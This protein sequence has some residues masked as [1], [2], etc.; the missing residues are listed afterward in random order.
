[1]DGEPGFAV[2]RYAL[3]FVLKRN[4]GTVNYGD[5]PHTAYRPKWLYAPS[6]H[7]RVYGV[8]TH[9]NLLL[10]KPPKEFHMLRLPPAAR[11]II[12]RSSVVTFRLVSIEESLEIV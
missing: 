1:M 12:W 8:R 6:F 10:R 2:C 9:S 5:R 3:A 11:A 7:C 4:S